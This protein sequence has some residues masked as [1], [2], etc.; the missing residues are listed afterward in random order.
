MPV[1]QLIQSYIPE[2]TAWRRDLHA[3]PETAFEEFRTADLVA[4]KLESFGI[5]VHRGLAGTGVVGTLRAGDSARAIGLRADMDALDIL[6]E[7][8][9]DYASTQAG[10][11]HACGHDGHTVMLLGAARYLAETRDFSGTVQFIFQPAEENVAGGR[12]MVEDGLFEL[13]PVDDVYGMH[14]TPGLAVGKIGMRIGP[15]MAAADMFEITIKAK[16]SHGAHPHH[17]GD[18][19]VTGAEVVMALQRIVSRNVNPMQAAVV[20]VT[21]FHAGTNMNVIP[22]SVTIKGTCR[23]H[24]PGVGDFIEQRMNSI[25][26]GICQAHAAEWS[27]HYDRRYP[28]TINTETETRHALQAAAAVCGKDHVIED[29]PA[30]MGSEDFAWMLRERP[31]CYVRLG[32]GEHSKGSCVVHN[33]NYDF[34]DDA[35][36]YG[37]SYWATLAEQQLPVSG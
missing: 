12:V 4:Q 37:A 36:V 23:S 25:I 18:A 28:A 10:K 15:A 1:K 29:Y 27:I 34:N 17:G 5:A 9:F 21:Q 14:N 30:S 35:I 2:L 16:G 8:E 13:F 31:G 24:D 26:E 3:H 20:S 11:M 6:E 32:N 7:N 33:P 22:E 19:I